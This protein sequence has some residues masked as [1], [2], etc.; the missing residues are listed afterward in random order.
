MEEKDVVHSDVRFVL[1][2]L[3]KFIDLLFVVMY[4]KIN[5]HKYQKTDKKKTYK[6]RTNANF[7][8]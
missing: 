3:L 6:K 5:N 7:V 1:R 2:A 4:I 8:Y